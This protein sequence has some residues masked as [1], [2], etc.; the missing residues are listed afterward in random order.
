MGNKFGGTWTEEK[1]K[2]VGD[3]I[4]FYSTAL[5]NQKFKKIYIDCFAGSGSVLIK[6]GSTIAGSAKIALEIE[7]KF[8]EY[9]FIEY[10]K[11]NIKELEMLKL[12][13]P[14]QNISVLQG[15]CNEILPQLLKKI[16]WKYSRGVLFI[17]PFAT[18]F[19][20]SNLE[21]VAGTK[22]IDVWY[23]FPFSAINR[24][25]KRDGNIDD[26]WEQKLIECLGTDS[27]KNELYK[28][29]PQLNLFGEQDMVKNET[30]SVHD[31]ILNRMLNI[32]PYVSPNYLELKNS[33]NSVMFILFLLISSDD[34]RVHALVKKVENY[35]LR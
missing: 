12:E 3:Y 24:L 35:I 29:N 8:D 16:N 20:Y 5:K 27:W 33:Q 7:N 13:Y 1:L 25:L 19:K 34:P 4:N 11:E 28:E 26:K 21:L 9:Y 23:L 17:D 2:T 6:D 10:K 18:Q 32:F 30:E 14:G 15:D 22:A 31:F